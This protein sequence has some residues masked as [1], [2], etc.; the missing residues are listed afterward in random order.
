MP[1]A[2]WTMAIILAATWMVR[3]LAHAPPPP[4]VR[5]RPSRRTPPLRDGCQPARKQYI[6]RARRSPR[7]AGASDS[8][9]KV[10]TPC[11]HPS[12]W[13][14]LAMNAAVP[15]AAA[16]GCG[17]ANATDE[18]AAG[19]VASQGLTLRARRRWAAAGERRAAAAGGGGRL[20]GALPHGQVLPHQ[21]G[22]EVRAPPCPTIACGNTPR[23]SSASGCV[24]LEGL[25][26]LR[27]WLLG[28]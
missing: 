13:W 4:A 26:P 5:M 14:W 20:E 16:A 11:R 24:A 27:A 12:R 15:A 18:L 21:L 3:V 22:R 10:A 23:A 2:A 28:A 8:E 9:R 6:R 25:M 19:N 1:A 7:A 17:R